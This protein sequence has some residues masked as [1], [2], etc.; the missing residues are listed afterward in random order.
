MEV[1]FVKRSASLLVAALLCLLSAAPARTSAAKDVWTRVRSKNFQLVGNASEQDIRQVAARLEQF[2]E[3]FTQLLPGDHFDSFVP[4]TVV[5]FNS[6]AAYRPFKPLYQGQPAE[7]AGYFK[8]GQ[9]ADYITLSIDEQHRSGRH[10]SSLAFHEYVHLLVRNN[11]AGA[12]LWF[13]E[14]LAEYYSTL[15]ISPDG[16]RV[17]LGQPLDTRA[18]TL[19]GGE[20]LSLQSLFE[21]DR[22]S[23]TYFEP[24]KRQIFYAESW[25]LVHYLLNGNEG[26]RRTQAAQY[27]NLRAAGTP[28]EEAFR[29]A[30]QTD[31]ATLES[32]LKSYV[33]LAQYPAQLT[34]FAQP[35]VYNSQAESAPMSEAESLAVLGDLL[36][37]TDAVEEAENY[38]QQAVVLAPDLDAA[39]TSLG[40]LRLRQN[41]FD[42]AGKFLKRA[43]SANAKNYLAHYTYAD[44]LVREASESDLTIEGFEKKTALL[45]AE[46]KN[47]IEL[48][49]RFLNAYRLLAQVELERSTQMDE[50]TAIINRAIAIA[51][52][53]YEFKLLL[54]QVHLRRDEVAP[55]REIL[56]DA[57]RYAPDSE[58]RA[59]ARARRV[60]VAAR[61][62]LLAQLSRESETATPDALPLKSA[63]PCDMPE[64]GPQ[65]KKLRF[66]G[67]QVCGMLK[68]VECNEAGVLLSIEIGECTLKLQ[69]TALNHIRFVTYTTEV[70]GNLNCGLREPANPVLVTFRPPKN[71]LTKFD[72]EVIAVE[73]IPRDWRH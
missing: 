64:P 19:R 58:M 43:I 44:T 73:F 54:A 24:D 22:Y 17:T 20:W 48:A 29:A 65:M 39:L 40:I 4:V 30:F 66:E 68:Q 16:R 49:P 70:R 55:A 5:V 38:L 42:E 10:T 14:G 57:A 46:L 67:E 47:A 56:A 45:R 8:S 34:T 72:G 2:R 61:A 26:R 21:V 31:F 23:P 1:N 51:P 25:A 37:H 6:D 36:L 7:V 69:S 60:K 53:R 52:Q 35:V 9:D 28:I 27:A 3:V 11:F 18:Q 12:P 13:N 32:E 62:E 71:L 50:A 15:E 33:R 59:K 63:Q 41:R